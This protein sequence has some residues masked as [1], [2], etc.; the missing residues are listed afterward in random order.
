[1][2]K[3]LIVVDFQNDFIDGA[4]GFPKAKELVS[5]IKNKINEYLNN[6][7]DIIYTLDTHYDNY[8]DTHEGKNLPVAHCILDTFGHKVNNE[9]DYLDKALKVFKKNTDITIKAIFILL[10]STL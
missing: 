1:M 8:L 3:L 2:K 7:D 5:V 4:L 6:N 10:I 9:C